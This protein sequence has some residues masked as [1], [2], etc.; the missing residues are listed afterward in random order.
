[1]DTDRIKYPGYSDTQ[2]SNITK[3]KS[4]NDS[5]IKQIIARQLVRVRQD[6]KEWRNALEDAE[7]DINPDRTELMRV[8]KDVVLDNH[9]SSLIETRKNKILSSKF[10]VEDAEGNKN[11]DLTKLLEKQWF[12]KFMGFA[13]DEEFYG[14]ALIEFGPI[15]NDAFTW[16]KKIREEFVVPEKKLVKKEIGLNAENPDDHTDNIPYLQPPWSNWSI[17]LGDEFNLGLLMKLSPHALWK[18]NVLGAWSERAELFG[19]PI[20]IGKTNIRDQVRRDNM[21]E[22]MINMG[23]SA[24]ATFDLKDEIQMIE[25]STT[26]A[27]KIY[28]E[29]I[30]RTNS[31]M[32]KLI[33][34][35]TATVDEKSFVGSAEVQ[36]RNSDKYTAKDKRKMKFFVEDH[37]FPLMKLHGIIPDQEIFF[38]WDMEEKLTKLNKLEVITQLAKSGYK[39]ER[40]DVEEEFHL[41]LQEPEELP[42]FNP[43]PSEQ[44]E[45]KDGKSPKTA[46]ESL[47]EGHIN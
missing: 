32:S 27:H 33:L 13:M 4:D 22:M 40:E 5:I 9:L 29:L 34:G 8:Y 18:K 42:A 14:H 24:W 12:F 44:Q 23:G 41:K 43:N 11:D 30:E 47:Y 46:V 6:I 36:E 21:D 37:L 31:E 20:R 28:N 19:Q 10:W 39:T 1:M 26:D 38:A 45:K 35:G 17:A 2:I 7:R 15:V 3:P 16:V 25:S